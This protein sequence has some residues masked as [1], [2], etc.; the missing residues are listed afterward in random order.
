MIPVCDLHHVRVH[1]CRCLS[2]LF[3]ALRQLRSL[4]LS[5][6]GGMADDALTHL[7]DAPSLAQLDLHCCWRLTDGG[8]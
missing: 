7:A 1:M 4:S 5:L 6:C 2:G 3:P 8:G